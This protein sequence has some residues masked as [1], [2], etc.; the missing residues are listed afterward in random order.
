MGIQLQSS[1]LPDRLKVWEA[2]DQAR[3]LIDPQTIVPQWNDAV[4]LV[5]K[6]AEGAIVAEV[7]DSGPL[8]SGPLEGAFCPRREE[9]VTLLVAAGSGKGKVEVQVL[10]DPRLAR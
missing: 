7:L 10:T 1:Q 4:S 3:K 9:G 5:I 8:L 2:L 6:D